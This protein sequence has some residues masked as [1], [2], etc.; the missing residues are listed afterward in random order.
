MFT[1]NEDLSIYATRGDIVFFEVS[2]EDEGVPYHF[3]PGDIVR[4]AIYGKKDAETCVMQKDFPV[5]EVCEKVTIYLEEQDTKIG[6]PISKN[7]DYWY[8]VV[9]N[10]DTEPQTII[11]YD[12]D[13]AK[14]FRLFPESEEIDDNY[15]PKEEDFPVVDSELDMTSPRPVANGA[16]AKAVAQILDTCERT[17][18]AVEKLYVTPDMFG[19]IG[20]GEADDTEAIQ[21]ALDSGSSVFLPNGRYRVSTLTVPYGGSIFGAN[22]DGCSIIAERVNL[23]T[24]NTLT[25]FT[26]EAAEGA[27]DL[28][29]IS[30]KDAHIEYAQI[31]VSDM[32][33]NGSDWQENPPNMITLEVSTDYTF[34]GMYG[35]TFQ[36]IVSTGYL[37][38]AFL[39]RHTF[40]ADE[41][42]WFT[43]VDISNI[44]ILS[45]LCGIK[46]EI[47][48]GNGITRQS[49]L[50]GFR[51]NFF[52]MQNNIGF[53]KAL[54]D[55]Y[56]I[57]QSMFDGC[58]LW[59]K[60]GAEDSYII[61]N[62]LSRIT[63]LND[64]S[65]EYA[66][67]LTVPD[68]DRSYRELF[69]RIVC[70]YTSQAGNNHRAGYRGEVIDA[71]GDR[72]QT[73]APSVPVFNAVAF[74]NAK[75]TVSGAT[76]HFFGT[77]VISPDRMATAATVGVIGFTAGKCP[78]FATR[79][80]T[81]EE[82]VLQYLYS[83]AYLPNGTTANRPTESNIPAGYIPVGY[84]YFD[85][86]LG[87]PVWRNSNGQWVDASGAVV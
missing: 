29:M 62:T 37:R 42:A 55:L 44:F 30:A 15:E 9:L 16:I 47:V 68:N 49:P 65:A 1:V 26:L 36:N 40:N 28:L 83:E 53:T 8:E 69:N 70:A 87:K 77:E 80:A 71:N 14:V 23:T 27:T 78:V 4:M 50:Q 60:T 32:R 19:A 75:T 64:R 6:E 58:E 2:A 81:D 41:D 35:L 10:P 57:N 20:D 76:S 48:W 66:N 5:N 79:S 67:V 52:N 34:K 38:N 86:T 13:G 31:I 18:A 3:Q 54:F 46:Q 59:D 72:C 51:V 63:I 82:Y 24:H 43:N 56:Y 74:T 61:R 39:F 22:K 12:E 33:F 45:A 84:M 11:G 7:K 85:R 73:T 21:T 25:N 17:N